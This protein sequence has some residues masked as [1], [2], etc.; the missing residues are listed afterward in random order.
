MTGMTRSSSAKTT[1]TGSPTERPSDEGCG[2][3]WSRNVGLVTGERVHPADQLDE[4]SAA[5]ERAV[6]GIW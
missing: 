3:C 4:E 2:P 6:P 5:V 1:M